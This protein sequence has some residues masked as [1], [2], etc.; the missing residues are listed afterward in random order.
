MPNLQ[1]DETCASIKERIADI[2]ELVIL[3]TLLSVLDELLERQERGQHVICHKF[4]CPERE[5]EPF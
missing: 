1:H 2:L 4:K 3:D 5:R